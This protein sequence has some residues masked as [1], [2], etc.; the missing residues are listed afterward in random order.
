MP[1]RCPVWPRRTMWPSA[2]GSPNSF[3]RT[4]TG[5]LSVYNCAET[6]G[7]ALW[8]VLAAAGGA[9]AVHDAVEATS[10]RSRSSSTSRV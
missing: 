6:T 3:G 10:D 1:E 8:A 4:A 9:Q 5:R 7:I 2:P